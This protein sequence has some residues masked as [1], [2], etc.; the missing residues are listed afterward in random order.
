MKLVKNSAQKQG[1][2]LNYFALRAW[3]CQID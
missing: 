3:N 1:K 2:I